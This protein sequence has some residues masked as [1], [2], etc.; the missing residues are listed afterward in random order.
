MMTFFH[1]IDYIAFKIRPLFNYL[2]GLLHFQMCSMLE[3]SW[4]KAVCSSF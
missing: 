2:N 4:K 1:N 3:Q